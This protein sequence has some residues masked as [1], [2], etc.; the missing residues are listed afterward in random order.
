MKKPCLVCTAAVFV[1]ASTALGQRMIACDSSRALYE[2]DITTGVKTSIGTISSNA[3]TT[4]EL[5]WD[6]VHGIM[7]L[8]STGNDSLYTL[9]LSTGEATLVGE[10]G[11]T[12]IVMHGLEYD[13][14]TDT[15]YGVSSHNNGLYTISRTTGAATLIGTSGLTSFS[16][17][18]YD[19]DADVMYL[20][21]SGADSFYT[22]DRGSGAA[23]L[24]GPL[25][26]ST[27][28]NSLAYN[29]D[30]GVLYMADNSTDSFYYMDVNTG[31]A[32]L[33]GPM[34]SGNILG[35][36]Y[37]PAEPSGPTLRVTGAC[38]GVVTVAWFD[39]TPNSQMGIVFASTTGNLIIPNG[40][41]QG[42][43]LGLSAQNI[44]LVNTVN[45]GGGSGQVSGNAGAG[46]CGGYLQLVIVDGSPCATSNGAQL[47]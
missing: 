18:G 30:N 43:Q 12:A 5:A 23:T 27:N 42:T 9:D 10:Y 13:P 35:L 31:Q 40:P 47:P 34:G 32:V 4:S 14:S 41:C 6:D 26:N 11:D 33:I 29:R 46:A 28:P 2:V 17:I 15:L 39:A 25:V 37:I 20:S 19:S 7:Y 3:S 1:F 21:N 36:A 38:P 45:T 8:S 16:N 24:I 22:V 44:Q